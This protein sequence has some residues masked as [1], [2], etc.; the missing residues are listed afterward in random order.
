MA[1]EP[2]P[3][4][5]ALYTNEYKKSD[6]HPDCK[7]TILGMDG[8]TYDIAGWWKQGKFG[9]FLSLRMS[10]QLPKQDAPPRNETQQE[11]TPQDQ[12]GATDDNLPF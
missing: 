12:Q 6:K 5:G 7:G 2:K 4:D 10:V 8:V 3:G 11:Q 1:Y 9:E